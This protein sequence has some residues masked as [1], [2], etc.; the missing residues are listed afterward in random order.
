VSNDRTVRSS[1]TLPVVDGPEVVSGPYTEGVQ[2]RPRNGF[3]PDS[4]WVFGFE[5]AFEALVARGGRCSPPS[6]LHKWRLV[7]VLSAV[8]VAGGMSARAAEATEYRA[9]VADN[10]SRST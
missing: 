10:G 6:E 5:S 9:Y 4:T 7:L 3:L 2:M 8:L 1:G